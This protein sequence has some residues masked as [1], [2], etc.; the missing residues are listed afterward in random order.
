M[1][2]VAAEVRAL[3]V[4][5]GVVTAGGWADSEDIGAAVAF[6]ASPAARYIH[7]RL[8]VVDGGWMGR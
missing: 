8:L 7:G 6:L 4:R 1:D 5:A 3:G 2:D